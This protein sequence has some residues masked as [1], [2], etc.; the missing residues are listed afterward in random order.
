MARPAPVQTHSG[1]VQARPTFQAAG[2]QAAAVHGP[3]GGNFAGARQAEPPQET[4]QPWGVFALVRGDEIGS[5]DI[6][7]LALAKDGVVRG[8]YY[9]AL[10]DSTQPAYGSL[11]RKSQRLAWSIGDKK[12]TVYETGLY[13]LTLEETTVLVHFGQERTEQCRLFR[14]EQPKEDGPAPGGTP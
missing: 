14:V 9:N 2:G 5:S 8:N 13:N 4:W 10:T 6:F 12:D 1:P 3:Y 7:Q 11:D